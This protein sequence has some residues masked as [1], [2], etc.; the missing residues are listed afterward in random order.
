MSI[1]SM[2]TV[3]WR[4]WE[5]YR[6]QV[7]G[8]RD[9]GACQCETEALLGSSSALRELRE[10][11]CAFTFVDQVIHARL[12]D[13][14]QAFEQEWRPPK[15][16]FHPAPGMAHGTWWLGRDFVDFDEQRL[17]ETTLGVFRDV[18]AWFEQK[19]PNRG[20]EFR[21]SLAAEIPIEF[22][23]EHCAEARKQVDAAFAEFCSA[24]E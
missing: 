10:F 19:F 24:C 14:H 18:Y 16:H 5:R 21:D 1:T 17:R 4:E 15:L 3:F 9:D 20:R 12:R 2:L 13:V 6:S 22:A 11:L 7:G 23:G 8:G